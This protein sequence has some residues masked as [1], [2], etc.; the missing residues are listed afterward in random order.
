MDIAAAVQ[1]LSALAQETRLAVFRELVQAGPEGVN[2][3]ALAERLSVAQATLSFHLKELRHAG[4]IEARQDGRFLFYSANFAA[5]RALV[6]FLTE[7]C[8]GLG[9]DACAATA[10]QEPES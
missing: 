3:G 5:M 4:L 6:D 2:P 7:N 9:A 8:C 10:C 1:Q